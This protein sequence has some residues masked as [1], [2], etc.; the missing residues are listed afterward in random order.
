MAYHDSGIGLEAAIL[1]A[2]EGA[3]VVLADIKID[4]AEKAASAIERE[5]GATVG[6]KAFA[7]KADVSRE[8][9]VKALVDV[10]VQKFGRLDV[11]VCPMSDP[12]TVIRI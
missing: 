5:Y 6:I 3:N 12:S 7:V 8:E 1:F 10:T 4:A 11:M 2:S 9:E